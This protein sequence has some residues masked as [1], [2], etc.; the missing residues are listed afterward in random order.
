MV[1]HINVIFDS[2]G[3][4]RQKE[5]C[6]LWLDPTVNDIVYGGSKGSGKSYLGCSLIFGDALMF[7]GTRYFIAR[8]TR[9]DLVKH[10]TPS[11][12]EVLDSW[13]IPRS[14]YK[15]NG[16]DNIWKLSNGS[17]V[18]FLDAKDEPSDPE[19]H[20]FGSMQMTR[21]W[22]EEAGEFTESA[23]NNLHISVG[24]WK[25][26]SF[27]LPLP[28][29]LLQTCN[30]TKNYLFRDYYKPNKEGTLDK[31]KAF[32]QAYPEDN[33]ML[34]NG[35]LENLRRTL[36][37]NEKE[38]LLY[39]NWEYDDSPDALIDYE[40]TLDMW[41]N[42]VDMKGKYIVVDVA[43]FGR[44]TTRI[45]VWKGLKLTRLL[46]M[47]KSGVDEVAEVIKSVAYEEQVPYSCI[48]VDEDGV[49]GGVRDLL[50]GTKGFIANSSAIVIAS[51]TQNF[52][53]LKAQCAYKLSEMINEHKIAVSTDIDGKDR[54]LLIEDLGMIRSKDIDK[55]GKLKLMPKDEVKEH[56]GRSPD[57]GDTFIMR[58]F[59]ELKPKSGIA[60]SEVARR[61]HLIQR[62]KR[63]SS[64]RMA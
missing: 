42:A 9:A 53:N 3:N 23:K 27:N 25:N 62:R 1:K 54:E 5:V 7:P 29:K 10:T 19:F 36:S 2:H 40:A 59:F 17:E 45:T 63:D 43:R 48:I 32:V 58:M 34:P 60:Q 64:F 49:G 24:R 51:E 44:D 28:G 39:G 56:L 31:W 46:T 37:K 47:E 55:G 16:Q 26:D 14:Q 15:Y 21:G 4:E 52:A 57:I 6:R 41:T 11:V 35:Y 38:R 30:P 20:R 8:K 61:R 18:L 50:R 12:Y 13:G 33:K 22:I